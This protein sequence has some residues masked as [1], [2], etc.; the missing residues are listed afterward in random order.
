MK[1]KQRLVLEKGFTLIELLVVMAILV[2]LVVG[3]AV[4]INPADKIRQAS[5]SRVLNSFGAIARASEAYTVANN[6]AYPPVTT[7]AAFSSAL[8][9]ANELKVFPSAPSGYEAFQVEA[10]G[11][12]F[13]LSGELKSS[14]YGACA[15]GTFR[16]I[17]Y[18]SSN[19]TTCT[20]CSTGATANA[21]VTAV[22]NA[23]PATCTAL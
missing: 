10:D 21:A 1:L 2:V 7:L 23:A 5:D 9:T 15:A 19:G 6:G 17:R 11:T 14:K 13:I 16:I 18:T 4:A 20:G 12:D 3:L 8:T 22:T